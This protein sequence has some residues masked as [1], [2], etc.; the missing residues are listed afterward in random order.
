MNKIKTL[1]ILKFCFFREGIIQPC[2]VGK[3]GKPKP[4]EHVLELEE[5]LP[6]QQIHKRGSDSD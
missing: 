6:K 1:L 3:D 5:H 4:V 2:R